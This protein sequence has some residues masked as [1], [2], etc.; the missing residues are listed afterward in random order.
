MIIG[1]REIE[2]KGQEKRRTRTKNG[3]WGGKLINGGER[4]KRKW[5]E[6]KISSKFMQSE[7]KSNFRNPFFPLSIPLKLLIKI[8]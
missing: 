5:R 2:K 6:L 7:Q 8:L 3:Y 4:Q 1:E